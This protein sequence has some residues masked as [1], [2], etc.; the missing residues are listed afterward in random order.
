[1]DAFVGET[2]SSVESSS[3]SKRQPVAFLKK[4]V[5]PWLISFKAHGSKL[6]KPPS[7]RMETQRFFIHLS[8]SIRVSSTLCL[9]REVDDNNVAFGSEACGRSKI[10]ETRV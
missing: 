7:M 8:N 10:E 5:L 1:M 2:R 9:M 6:S 3:S 4:S